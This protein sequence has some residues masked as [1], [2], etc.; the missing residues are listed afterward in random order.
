MTDYV[1]LGEYQKSIEQTRDKRMKWWREARFGM[2]IHYGTYALLGRNEWVRALENIPEAEYDTLADRFSP[3]P[4]CPREWAELAAASGMKYMVMTTKHHEGFCLWDTEQT[5]YNSV[6]RGPKR[7]IVAEYVEACREFGMK[8]GFYYSLMDWHHPDGGRCAYDPD[9]RRRFLDFTQACVRELLTKYG[10]IDVL[11]YDVARPFTSY[12]G[13]ES[14]KMNQMVRELQPDIIV[15]NR[16]ILQE[17]FGTPEGHV[18]AQ[19]HDW[20]ACMTFNNSSWGYVPSDQV[21]P[22]SYNVR[23]ILGMLNTACAGAGNLLLNIGPA[24]DGSVPPETVE[25]LKAAGKWLEKYGNAVYGCLDRANYRANAC[26]GWSRKG[27]RA[28]Y[29][30][31]IWPEAEMSLGGFMTRLNAVRL[32]PDGKPVKFEQ[33]G[34]RIILKDLGEKSPDDI[35]GIAVMEFEFAEEP[36]HLRCSLTP[37]LHNGMDNSP[38]F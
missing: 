37:A 1:P 23:G 32:L 19:E 24:P 3:R 15:N 2:F 33:K 34:Q 28:F 16:S 29:W 27:S 4:G 12:E 13:W 5:D 36:K 38:M 21:A 8:V 14:L 22:D 18:T 20:E 25:P 10:E 11:W 30:C 31:R 35:A 26:G 7:D 9:A 17:D 6:K